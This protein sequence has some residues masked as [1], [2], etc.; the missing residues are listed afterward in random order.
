LSKGF[1]RESVMILSLYVG[2]MVVAVIM[3]V[4]YGKYYIN[5]IALYVV[6]AVNGQKAVILFQEDDVML[7]ICVGL[8]VVIFVVIVGYI[9]Y[10]RD[11]SIYVKI[12]CVLALVLLQYFRMI[13]LLSVVSVF[14][15]A[16]SIEIF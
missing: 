13:R 16:D 10:E 14:V 8:L 9:I 11:V 1:G 5:E 3:L 12:G 7:E 6:I 4:K 2:I 15:F